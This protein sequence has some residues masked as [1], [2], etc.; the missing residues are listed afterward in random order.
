MLRKLARI[1]LDDQ[2]LL[3]AG[4][5]LIARRRGDYF[6]DNIRVIHIK[7]DRKT[8]RMQ[9]GPDLFD[10]FRL[11]L[12]FMDSNH[13]TNLH[14]EGWNVDAASVNRIKSVADQ[15]SC[16]STGGCQAKSEDGVVKAHFKELQQV[17]TR[18][19]RSSFG[20]GEVVSELTFHH[21]VDSAKFL[22]FAQLGTVFGHLLLEGV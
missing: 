5:N 21:A 18:N 4:V 2:L 10:Y 15:L 20:L 17:F 13:V 16:M 9:F 22:F 14:L 8:A 19:A 3:N 6:T 1:E 12:R 11:H 7:P